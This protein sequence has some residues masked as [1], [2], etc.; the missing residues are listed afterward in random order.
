MREITITFTLDE[1]DLIAS[2]LREILKKESMGGYWLNP[3][4]MEVMD[5]LCAKVSF[6]PLDNSF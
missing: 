6:A 2:A 5:R 3:P 1:R 4:E